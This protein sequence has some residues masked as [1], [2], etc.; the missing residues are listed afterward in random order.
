MLLRRRLTAGT[1][2]FTLKKIGNRA[3][4]LG[5]RRCLGDRGMADAAANAARW[6]PAARAGSSEA[7]GQVLEACRGYLLLIAGQELEPALRAKGGASDL[8]QQTF[9]EAQRDFAGFHGT[10]HE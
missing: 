2:R 5:R 7:L 3:A 8:V 10:T 6:L 9:L 1:R 4:Q